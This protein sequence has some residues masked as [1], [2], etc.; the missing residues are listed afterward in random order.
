M[1]TG[2]FRKDVHD[3]LSKWCQALQQEIHQATNPYIHLKINQLDLHVQKE[4]EEEEE[5]GEE[6]KEA[7]LASLSRPWSS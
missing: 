6:E 7:L 4:E 5:E 3:V 1:N 2:V